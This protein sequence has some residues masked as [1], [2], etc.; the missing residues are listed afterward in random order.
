MDKKDNLEILAEEFVRLELALSDSFSENTAHTVMEMLPMK[1]SLLRVRDAQEA[2][3]ID[4]GRRV[5]D[6]YSF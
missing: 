5:L 6:L 4:G 2:V 1:L 3:Q